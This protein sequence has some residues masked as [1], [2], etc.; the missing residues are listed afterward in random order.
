MEGRWYE[1]LDKLDILDMPGNQKAKIAKFTTTGFIIGFC[2]LSVY[3]LSCLP[4][5]RDT[6]CILENSH[7]HV[8]YEHSENKTEAVGHFELFSMSSW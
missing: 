1:K 7:L 8:T 5:I 2:P 3:K 6:V 4:G